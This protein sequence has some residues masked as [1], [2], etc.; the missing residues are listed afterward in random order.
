MTI[1][2]VDIIDRSIEKTQ[3]RLND[4]AEELVTED[5]HHAYRV[6][7]A[8][9]HALVTSFGRRGGGARRAAADL[10][11]RRLLRGL[12]SQPHPGACARPGQLPSEDRRRPGLAG[13]TEA[14]F[15]ATAANRVFEPPR[16]RRRGQER[17]A[18]APRASAG[19]PQLR[20]RFRQAVVLPP[21]HAPALS[22]LKHSSQQSLTAPTWLLVGPSIQSGSTH[23][24]HIWA[25]GSRACRHVRRSCA[26]R[27]TAPIGYPRVPRGTA[28]WQAPCVSSGIR[29][30]CCCGWRPRLR[31]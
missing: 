5:G 15:A 18:R 27:S 30:R 1:T 23:C 10:R 13:E 11:A 21:S 20:G 26:L 3:I 29:W 7:R 12:G 31:R 14:S 9:L 17:A 19:A 6:L 24:W 22:R 25:R 2:R 4:L 8:F 16:I 28:P